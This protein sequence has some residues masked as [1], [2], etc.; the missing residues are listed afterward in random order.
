MGGLAIRAGRV[1]RGTNRTADQEVYHHTAGRTGLAYSGT[2]CVTTAQ[3]V[4]EQHPTRYQAGAPTS[5]VAGAGNHAA[6]YDHKPKSERARE[7]ARARGHSYRGDHRI[8]GVASGSS[9]LVS[10]RR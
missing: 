9:A 4:A 2:G 10:E 5:G 7:N 1:S 3:Q 6:D 8:P